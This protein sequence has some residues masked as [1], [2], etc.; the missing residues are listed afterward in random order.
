MGD[1]IR[2][3]FGGPLSQGVCALS[4]LCLKCNERFVAIDGECLVCHIEDE[5]DLDLIYGDDG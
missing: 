2:A 5:P 1:V 4:D 3:S